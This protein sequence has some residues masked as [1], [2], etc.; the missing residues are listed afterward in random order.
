MRQMSKLLLKL[1]MIVPELSN[2]EDFLIPKYFHTV[3]NA[4]LS[5][6]GY[7]DTNNTYK[8][9]SV[10]KLGHSIIQCTDILESQLMIN[11]ASA[12]LENVKNFSRVYQKEWKFNVSFNACQYINKK[13]S[14]N[15]LPY[16]IQKIKH[17]HIHIFQI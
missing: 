11:N 13:S 4:T 17:S 7:N 14:I 16:L 8:C 1:R 9:P 15:Q 6:S 10:A 2:L 12:E 5:L 3:V